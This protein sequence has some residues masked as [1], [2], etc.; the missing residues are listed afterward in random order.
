MIDP[1]LICKGSAEIRQR[2]GRSSVEE[3]KEKK[4]LEVA[5][6]LATYKSSKFKDLEIDLNSKSDMPVKLSSR[7]CLVWLCHTFV[8]LRISR[9]PTTGLLTG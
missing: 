8:L 6:A 5:K 1:A 4:S 2:F 7:H 3:E 9:K